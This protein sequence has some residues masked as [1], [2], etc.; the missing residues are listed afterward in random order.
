MTSATNHS[1]ETELAA[2]RRPAPETLLDNVLGATG[3]AHHYAGFEGPIGELYVAWSDEGVSCV[4]P[5]TSEEEFVEIFADRVGK[6]LV[7]AHELPPSLES[8]LARAVR[9]G[10]PGSLMFDL[11]GLTEFQR[12]VLDATATIPPG[13][14]RSYGWIAK[15]I[16]RPGAVRAVGSALNRNPVPVL[17]P[18]HRVGRSDGSIGEYAFGPE[19]KRSLLEAEGADP[20]SLEADAERG[21]RFVGSDTTHIFCHPTCRNAR[22]ITAKHRREFRSSSV[23]ADAGYRP[24][25]VCRPV[26]AA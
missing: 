21:V 20:E 22:R 14:V 7:P 2:L 9:N 24:C 16:G 11:S 18:C 17:I 10:K 1:I 12:A 6:P 3:L 15:E 19:M 26:A 4:A 8:K 25:K 5:A 13:E 23:A